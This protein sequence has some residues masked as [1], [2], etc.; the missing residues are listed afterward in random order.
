MTLH[1]GL[2]H[3]T[4]YRY[5][6]RVRMQPQI[7]R[8]H[9]A[10]HART[11]VLSYS[12]KVSPAEHFINWQHDPF[13]N[14]LA[15]IVFPEPVDHFEIIV[16]LVAD[17]AVVNPFDFFLEP[18][19]EKFPFE[20]GR[21]LTAD[22]GAY[23]RI[24]DDDPSV[25]EWVERHRP[26]EPL[27]TI[28][29]LVE[30]NRALAEQVRYVIRE[31]PGVQTPAE[32]LRLRSGSCRDT[33]WLLV[34][35]LRRMGLACRFV[36]GYLIQLTPD[37]KS[38]TGPVGTS[39]DFT[40]LHAWVEVFLPGAGWIGLDPTSGLLTGEGHIPVACAPEPGPAAPVSGALDPCQVTFAHA[41]SVQRLVESPRATKP[42][43]DAQWRA[44]DAMGEK[45]V[46]SAYERDMRLT[47]G[48]E[49]TFVAEGEPDSPAWNT[50]ALGGGKRAYA[51]ALI[52]RLRTHFAPQGLLHHG[53]G[54]WYPGEQLPRWAFTLY[55]RADGE[56]I[57][58][59]ADL[60]AVEPG[61]RR[62]LAPEAAG[63]FLR[64]L[65]ERLE[66]GGEAVMAA[67]EDPWH[68]LGQERHLPDGVDATENELDDP[69]ARERLARVFER[70]LDVVA[71]FVLPLQVWQAADR[72]R[73]WVSE[74]WATRA[75]R[76]WLVPGDSS[77]GYRLPLP[78]LAPIAD[79]AFPHVFARDPFAPLDP[80]PSNTQA[81]L[82][83]APEPVV[84]ASSQ[85]YSDQYVRT[86]LTT[87][88]RDGV[89][90]VFMP[91][92][93]SAADY[94]ALVAEIET[95]AREGGWRVRLEGYTMPEDPRIHQIKVTPDPGV[96]EVNV[97]PARSW[98]EQREIIEVLYEQA[99][100]CGL[101]AFKFLI[102]GRQVGTGGGAHLV[103]G[104]ATPADSPF[105]RRPDLLRSMIAYWQRH[106][107]LSYLF[108]GLF[109]GPTS[110]SPRIDE[111]RH[112][113]LFEM[114]LAFR[115]VP[116]REQSH[117]PWLTDRIFRNLLVDVTGNTHRAEICIDKLYS[118]DGPTGRLGLV[119]L[120]AFEMPPHPRMCLVQQMLVQ[121]LVTMFWERP[122][123]GRLTT[124]G[125]T[126]HDRF[127]LPEFIWSDLLEVLDDLRAAGFDF[128][129]AWFEPHAEFRFPRFGSFGHGTVAVTVRQA[130]EPWHVM[131]EEGAVGGTVRY[132]DSSVERL[133]V[134]L[135]GAPPGRYLVLC[136]GHQIP[137]AATGR[138]GDVVGGVRFRAWQPPSSLHPGIGIDAPLT[139]DLHDTW[140]GRSVAGCT[141]HVGHPAGRN[142]E[143]FP[144]NAYEAEGR[145]LARFEAGGHTPGQQQPVAARQ[146]PAFVHTLDLRW[147]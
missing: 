1:V 15:R 52:R 128:D 143:V 31:E 78:S 77:I 19:A 41:M 108:S 34:H 46:R 30:I 64:A 139:F 48:G 103:L 42:Y 70:G 72:K 112:D 86:A 122:D 50:E 125:T 91:P 105:L 27:A 121:A 32:T 61:D 40:D 110:Q 47:I 12:L 10:G 54:K 11:P 101:A 14:R 80:L 13:G 133:E 104:G 45:V 38:L 137:L 134:R 16:D 6:R 100:Q 145:R 120:R 62:P 56:P 119:E 115:Q 51:D 147:T 114:A 113:A 4:L 117:P 69:M 65:A 142:F 33:S 60:L 37:V 24:L 96:I 92:L 126:L 88:V 123:D 97:Q 74:T 9:P 90:S 131:G 118:P 129:P 130:L 141:Y 81:H 68:F 76:L 63:E 25:L 22:L 124:W 95:A 135:S 39:H 99:R 138:D 71:G 102:D 106:P 140:Q 59:D 58:H 36:S 29:F 57:W 17:M 3:K 111:A 5:D 53:Q 18:H 94:L 136:N 107:A 87:E 79:A 144:V 127:M 67:Y 75:G 83:G 146:H 43:T 35:V 66:V 20:Y 49:P 26:R 21:A 109:I 89:L 98:A 73:R 116:G 2:T 55:W 93:P 44:I 84:P 23:T 82:P 28:D 132:V 85:G 7:I 8:L